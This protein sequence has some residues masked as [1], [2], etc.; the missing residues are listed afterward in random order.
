M[1]TRKKKTAGHPMRP[2]QPGRAQVSAQ[3][4]KT[5]PAQVSRIIGYRRISKDN[6]S[7][8]G[9]AAQS[10]AIKAEAKRLGA[11]VSEMFTDSGVSGA[12]PIEKR[13]ALLDALKALKAGD[14]LMVARRDRLARD[15]MLAGWICK[16]VRKRGAE[17][18]SADGTGNGTSPT[19]RLMSQIVDAFSEYER[20]LICTRTKDVMRIRRERGLKLGGDAPYGYRDLPDK[21]A[22]GKP[23]TRVVK[24]P[25][26]QKIIREVKRLRARG[27]T[28]RETGAMLEKA[29]YRNRK[30]RRFSPPTLSRML[31]R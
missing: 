25:T 6:G 21:D 2:S 31:R 23:I 4:S 8:L 28:L 12:A 5:K 19:D 14:V 20:A 13:L 11:P 18:R 9:L 15:A 17:V 7:G 30:G 22:D 16:E 29:G 3:V 1:T 24:D 10:V 27:A 26:E